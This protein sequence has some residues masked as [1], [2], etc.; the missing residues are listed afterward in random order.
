MI[1]CVNPCKIPRTVPAMH[2]I[3]ILMKAFQ[4]TYSIKREDLH[5]IKRILMELF[6]EK[7]VFTA[8]FEENPERNDFS[9]LIHIVDICERWQQINI[10]T[11]IGNCPL[12]LFSYAYTEES[13]YSKG[14]DG[15]EDLGVLSKNVSLDNIIN[16][17]FHPN[18]TYGNF[19]HTC[20]K[21]YLQYIDKRKNNF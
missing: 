6:D 4:D 15:I 12:Y 21:Y 17:S 2:W 11:N 5:I 7:G 19:L 20:S 8:E 3:D 18:S 1:V 10:K 14:Y 16:S 9:A 13:R